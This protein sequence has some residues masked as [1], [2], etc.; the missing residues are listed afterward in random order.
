M[1]T[2]IAV[3]EVNEN[4][5]RMKYVQACVNKYYEWRDAGLCPASVTDDYDALIYWDKKVN[6]GSLLDYDKEANYRAGLRQQAMRILLSYT[7]KKVNAS[8]GTV[9]VPGIGRLPIGKRKEERFHLEKVSTM[10]YNEIDMVLDSM[11][12]AVRAKARR[13]RELGAHRKAIQNALLAAE[14]EANKEFEKN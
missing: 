7:R 6:G 4:P 14:E 10:S 2:A 1:A 9:T 12:A 13:L 5:R 11:K 3:P 8:W